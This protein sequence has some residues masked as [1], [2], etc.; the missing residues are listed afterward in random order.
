[1]GIDMFD[2]F[3]DTV[4]PDDSMSVALAI[5]SSAKA[6]AEMGDSRTMLAWNDS[7]TAQESWEVFLDIPFEWATQLSANSV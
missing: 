6:K 7:K 4:D 3:S 1:M 5:V 2:Y